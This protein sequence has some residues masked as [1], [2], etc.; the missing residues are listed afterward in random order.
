M[1]QAN[2]VSH[3]LYFTNNFNSNLDSKKLTALSS[4]LDGTFVPNTL[5]STNVTFTG[6]FYNFFIVLS[7]SSN[8]LNSR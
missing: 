7:G 1:L 4:D 5:C 6:G 2:A 8:I 3:L